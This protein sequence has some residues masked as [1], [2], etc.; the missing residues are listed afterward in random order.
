[1]EILLTNVILCFLSFVQATKSESQDGKSEE[2]EGSVNQR[3][4]PVHPSTPEY[5][6]PPPETSVSLPQAASDSVPPDGSTTSGVD[7]KGAFQ[8][9]LSADAIGPPP[10]SRLRSS[11]D[12]ISIKVKRKRQTIM[13]TIRVT[14]Y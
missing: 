9:Q 6:N 8:R 2:S 11:V 7:R 5:N 10:L 3:I 12:S 4:S 14:K 13:A 1:M